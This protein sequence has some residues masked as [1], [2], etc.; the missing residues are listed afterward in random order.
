MITGQQFNGLTQ[1]Q[2]YGDDYTA[3]TN[4][5]LVRIRNKR[6]GKVRYCRS[7]NR[8]FA[9][10]MHPKRRPSPLSSIGRTTTQL[11]TRLF[12]IAPERSLVW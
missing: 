12:C 5:P 10:R 11:P 9:L 2:C 7:A 4:Y 3:A 6:S 1:C 8:S